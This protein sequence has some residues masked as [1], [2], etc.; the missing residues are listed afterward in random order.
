[1]FQLINLSRSAH[2]LQ[3]THSYGLFRRMTGVGGRPEVIIEYA[4]NMEG[5]WTEY[6]FRFDNKCY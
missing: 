2:H 1:M 4:D 3:L 5:P 6:N